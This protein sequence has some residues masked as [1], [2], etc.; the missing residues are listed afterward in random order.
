MFNRNKTESSERIMSE[1]ITKDRMK[2]TAK[3]GSII[4]E[5]DS[6]YEA[7]R[8]ATKA[9]KEQH[10]EYETWMKNWQT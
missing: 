3:D 8:V 9:L 2:I 7:L 1:R 10:S 6:P 5:G 4:Y